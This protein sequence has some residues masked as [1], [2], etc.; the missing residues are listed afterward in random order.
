[1]ISHSFHT[2]THK[3]TEEKVEKNILTAKH[4]HDYTRSIPRCCCYRHWWLS[5]H[6]CFFPCAPLCLSAEARELGPTRQERANL[7]EKQPRT[8]IY[9]SH[10]SASRWQLTGTGRYFICVVG[11]YLSPGERGLPSIYS[12]FDRICQQ[13]RMFWR[14]FVEEFFQKCQ[15]LN[16]LALLKL[17]LNFLIGNSFF[18]KITYFFLMSYT[19]D[20]T[21]SKLLPLKGKYRPAWPHQSKRHT[22]AERK[23]RERIFPV[24]VCWRARFQWMGFSLL[25]ALSLS[26]SFQFSFPH[27]FALP[28]TT[29]VALSLLCYVFLSLTLH[30][31]LA[32][33]L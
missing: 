26:L 14:W 19:R 15:Q 3:D 28:P 31:P 16:L 22:H 27:A 23:K 13:S 1:M 9:T 20:P 12:V 33:F 2:H 32:Q 4:T 5:E 7:C 17:W 8:R 29:G 11:R 6:N 25:S 18:N 30:F 24:H 10:W 21:C